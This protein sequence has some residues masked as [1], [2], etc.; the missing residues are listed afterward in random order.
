M[1]RQHTLAVRLTDEEHHQ[2]EIEAG[3]VPTSVGDYLRET[4]EV[5]R[6]TV[7]FMKL[8]SHKSN[9]LW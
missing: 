5:A 7:P 3:A 4:S 8:K 1:K 6:A 9:L 2:L